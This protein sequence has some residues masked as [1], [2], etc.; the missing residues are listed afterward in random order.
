MPCLQ[1][2][3]EIRNELKMKADPYAIGFEIEQPFLRFPL[4][5]SAKEKSSS[6]KRQF[7]NLLVLVFPPGRKNRSK[8]SPV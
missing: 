3:L 8:E 7:V 6:L 2:C 1:H 4:V 5:S